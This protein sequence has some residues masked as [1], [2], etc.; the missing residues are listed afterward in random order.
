VVIVAVSCTNK[1]QFNDTTAIIVVSFMHQKICWYC[2]NCCG[3]IHTSK[4]LLILWWLWYCNDCG[5]DTM[6]TTTVSVQHRLQDQCIKF[7]VQGYCGINTMI[8]T[9]LQQLPWY[10]HHNHYDTAMTTIVSSPQSPWYCNDHCGINT[11]ITTILQQPPQYHVQ[12]SPQYHSDC[13]SINTTIT[14]IL[15]RLPQYQQK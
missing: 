9:I 3:I 8:T 13:C 5:V 7:N 12:Q 10:Q 6:T 14:T 11:T 4:N 15:W 2:G 1:H